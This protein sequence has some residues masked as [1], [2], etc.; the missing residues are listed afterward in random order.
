MKKIIGIVVCALMAITALPASGMIQTN[1][2]LQASNLITIK[3][4]AK[5]TSITDANNLLGGAI[6]INDQISGKYTYATGVPDGY[7]SNPHTGMYNYTSSTCG[8]NFQAGGFVFKTDPSNVRFM[9][10]IE[11]NSFTGYS[12]YDV[13]FPGSINN[14]PLS[15][16][17]T[18]SEITIQLLDNTTTALS[19]DALPTTAPD[20]TKWTSK[21]LDFMG[22]DPAHPD[23]TFFIR[24]EVTKATKKIAGEAT[25]TIGTILPSTHIQ[26]IPSFME[27]ILEHFPHAFPVVRY[28]A[29][30]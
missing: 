25:P 14:L 11:D 17:M 30:N 4:E 15:N 29:R 24:A 19:S 28:L 26:P 20:L 2:E 8:M 10:I 21:D 18:V 22:N 6:H 5:V 12:Y 13:Y 16:G 27:W 9:F 7:P 3:I 23:K 1:P